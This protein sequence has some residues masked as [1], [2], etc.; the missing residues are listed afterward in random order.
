MVFYSNKQIEGMGFKSVYEFVSDEVKKCS[1]SGM[2]KI[3]D[4][5]AYFD[6]GIDPKASA[7][8]AEC[9]SDNPEN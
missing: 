1:S 2:V 6:Y 7:E 3:T 4:D 9:T 5:G 8:N